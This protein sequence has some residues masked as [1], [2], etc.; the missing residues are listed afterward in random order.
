MHQN[1]NLKCLRKSGKYPSN[2]GCNAMRIEVVLEDM[3]AGENIA[4]T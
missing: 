1:V 2:S 4:K 3:G